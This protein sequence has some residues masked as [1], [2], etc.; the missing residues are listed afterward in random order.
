MLVHL[1]LHFLGGMDYSSVNSGSITVNPM[2][3]IPDITVNITNDPDFEENE[4]FFVNFTGCSPGCM[5][6]SAN[7]TVT[8][9]IQDD[10]GKWLRLNI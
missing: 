3:A 8:V 10:D 1:L 4:T 2:S 9:T 5:I 7:D 6:A